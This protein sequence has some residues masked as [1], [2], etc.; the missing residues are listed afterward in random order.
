MIGVGRS[1]FLV[2]RST[3]HRRNIDRE[4][5]TEQSS[6]YEGERGKAGA[7]KNILMVGLRCELSD[8]QSWMTES[9]RSDL[10]SRSRFNT[11][12]RKNQKR[13]AKSGAAA[14][15]QTFKVAPKHANFWSIKTNHILKIIWEVVH[16]NMT[17]ANALPPTGVGVPTNSDAAAASPPTKEANPR[18]IIPIPPNAEVYLV[19]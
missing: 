17:H 3:K 13:C 6:D 19:T 11:S 18:S 2:R 4:Y 15:K 16:D 9:E 14:F 10:S 5:D 12:T 7:S 8:F 1:P